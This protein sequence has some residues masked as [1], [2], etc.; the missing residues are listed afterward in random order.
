[1]CHRLLKVTAGWKNVMSPK[2]RRSAQLM[3]ARRVRITESRATC[4]DQTE[5]LD[6]MRGQ[7]SLWSALPLPQTY[8]ARDSRMDG[9]AD[10]V[11]PSLNGTHSASESMMHPHCS[12]SPYVHNASYLGVVHSSGSQRHS[13]WLCASGRPSP[14]SRSSPSSQLRSPG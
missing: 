13:G 5:Y 1:M 9:D 12:G 10:L 6:C 3:P 2:W 14:P 8:H 11:G 7:R 4:R